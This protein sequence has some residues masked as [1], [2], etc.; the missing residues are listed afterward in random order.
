MAERKEVKL[1]GQQVQNAYR[2]EESKLQVAETRRKNLQQL[3]VETLGAE[4]SLKA[5]K[6]AA[7]SQKIMVSLGAGL[8]A[9]AK[10]ETTIEVK[11]GLGAGVLVKASTEDAL[12]ALDKRKDEIQK[13]LAAI[14]NE[15]A[16]TVQNLNSLGTVIQST[17]RKAKANKK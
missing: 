3:L 1:T 8:Y 5:I 11:T 12:K 2:Q 14:Q 17:Q 9:E 7:K 16:R 13:D 4:E 10:L 15:E 6:N